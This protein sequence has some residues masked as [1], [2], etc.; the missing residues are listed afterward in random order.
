MANAFIPGWLMVWL[1]ASSLIV[2]YDASYV[3]LRPASMEGGKLFPYYSAY[4]LYIQYDTLYGN[5]KDS[6]VVI[7]SWLNLVEVAL[8]LTA[9]TL[10][11][12]SCT[13]K[14]LVSGLMVI[15]GSAFIF[16]K[17]VIYLSY[18]HQFLTPPTNAPTI[19]ALL[20]F[21]IPSSLWV[22]FPFLAIITISKNIVKY[23]K[24]LTGKVKKA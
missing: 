5:L 10:S 24:D 19:Q 1:V 15:V 12:S 14:Q 18:D 3:L 8:T 16:W 23:V 22:I 13:I 2:I 11:F 4:A 7:Q 6:F 20:V 21:W 17:T 9:V